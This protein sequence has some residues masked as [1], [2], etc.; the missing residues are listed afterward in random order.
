MEMV[1][2]QVFDMLYL[3]FCLK[4]WG[5]NYVHA[6]RRVVQVVSMSA[7]VFNKEMRKRFL[8]WGGKGEFYSL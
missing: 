1:S 4:F 3:C 8:F 2:G 6:N 7:R 5:E